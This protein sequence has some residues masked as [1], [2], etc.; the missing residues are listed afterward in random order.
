MAFILLLYSFYLKYH[1]RRLIESW[2][3][4]VLA[5][6][7]IAYCALEILSAFSFIRFAALAAFW[8]V[9]DAVLLSYLLFHGKRNLGMGKD[10]ILHIIRILYKNAIWVI[11]AVSLFF[12]AVRTT[13]YNW[14]S[15][16]Y[17]LS[18][19]ANW[20][21][22]QSVRHYATHNIR[23]IVSP[24][25]AEFIN[26]HIYILS[27]NKD[28]LLNLL[29]CFSAL[30][31][32]WLVYE[33]AEK[34]GCSRPYAQLAA[35]LFYTCPIAFGEALTTQVDQFAALWLLI[36]MYY[37]LD[38]VEEKYRF[39]LDKE[40]ISRCLIMEG[41][42]VFGFLTKPSVLV[43]MAFLAVLLLIK[44]IRRKESA[45]V[46]IKLSGGGICGIVLTIMP[47]LLRNISSFGSISLPIA[48]QRQLVGTVRPAYVLVNGLKNFAFN[49]PTIYIPRSGHW[50]A[51]V[52]YRIAGILN[53]VIDDSSISEDGRVFILHEFR[54]Y[55]HDVAVNDVI[56]WCFILCLIWGVYRFRKQK[57]KVGKFYAVS[58]A[59]IFILFCC[60]VRWEPFVSRYMVSYLAVLCPAI[61]YEIEDFRKCMGNNKMAVWP[62]VIIFFLCFVDLIG[63]VDF[64]RQISQV[65]SADR[66]RGYFY[67]QNYL[68]DEYKE[69]CDMIPEETKKIGL[70][71]GS[72]TYEYPVWQRL[73]GS[74]IYMNHIMVNNESSQFEDEKFIPDCIISSFREEEMLE[75][76]DKKYYLRGECM[77]NAYLWLYCQ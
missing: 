33:L 34:I 72:D 15:M 7:C 63:L 76:H 39:Q 44:C 40:T 60:I 75:Y 64:H 19:I 56:A 30:T 4:A 57:N 23:E 68:Y 46:I 42:I 38:M 61:A 16:T 21:Q 28:I 36:F 17:H 69:V 26:L 54:T 50:A 5:W 71:L 25:L 41:C 20:A 49:L 53:V 9:V 62:E 6:V 52:V 77:D 37:Y 8:G 66:F 22:N 11:L 51:A 43:G 29:Q 59:A 58:A 1:E 67:S 35:F 10:F 3:R 27:G 18:R 32:V 13:P 55:G 74:D 31:N 45:R 73:E 47:E 2:I 14:D 48:G 24:V 12:L 65:G 70:L